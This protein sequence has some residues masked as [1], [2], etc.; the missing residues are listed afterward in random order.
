MLNESMSKNQ[1]TAHQTLFQLA[2]QHSVEIDLTKFKYEFGAEEWSIP[3]FLIAAKAA[4]LKA[5]YFKCNGA[6][7]FTKSLPAAATDHQ[8]NYFLILSLIKKP[9]PSN[10]LAL[11]TEQA[12][13]QRFSFATK[14]SENIENYEIKIQYVNQPPKTLAAKELTEIWSGDL[15]LVTSNASKLVGNKDNLNNIFTKYSTLFFEILLISFFLQALRVVLPVFFQV[16]IDKVFPNQ[17][18]QTLDVMLLGLLFSVLL[19]EGLKVIRQYLF[20]EVSHKI[21]IELD[22]KIHSH[23]L[24]VPT[25]YFSLKQNGHFSLKLK[26]LEG[27]RKFFTESLPIV[28][29]NVFLVILLFALMYYD[30]IITSVVV[31]AILLCSLI[32]WIYT[33]ASKRHLLNQEN[34]RADNHAF[35]SEMIASVR[36]IKATVSESRWQKRLLKKLASYLQLSLK[37]E[38][39]KLWLGFTRSLILW[40]AS[41]VVILIAAT[42]VI[43]GAFT[44]GAFI[45]TAILLYQIFSQFDNLNTHLGHYLKFSIAF[46][47]VKQY[48]NIEP[49]SK[50][51]QIP[52]S[53]IKG[54]VEFER[55]TFRY[56]PDSL[57]VLRNFELKILP[58]ETIGIIGETGAG[59][60]TISEL[61]LRN[62]K[63]TQG[64]I[65][66]DGHDVNSIDLFSLRRHISVISPE[67]RLFNGTVRENIC[68]S[69]THLSVHE[70]IEASM[71]AGAHEFICKLPEGYDTIIEDSGFN[72]SSSERLLIILARALVSNPSVLVFDNFFEELNP[73]ASQNIYKNIRNN[74]INRTTF[75]LSQS[76]PSFRHVDRIAVIQ[77]GE[78]VEIGSP[79]ELSLISNGIYRSLCLSQNSKHLELKNV[80]KESIRSEL[81]LLSK[82]L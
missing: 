1:P 70:M 29:D 2:Q 44:I 10:D 20:S 77:R 23:L 71:M 38:S 62:Y 63:T 61:L 58:G 53:D 56:K 16:L 35:Y 79:E 65:L 50:S 75:I 69:N 17:S 22:T 54:L 76:P 39:S 37:I 73:I 18:V 45:A 19:M 27:I 25:N 4:G 47:N 60:S 24:K 42:R 9:I 14:A 12:P 80:Q 68:T 81:T 36:T 72:L 52:L 15:I 40:I 28:C 32:S 78:I 7:L 26:E 82:F 11:G 6:E 41:L 43:D 66:I 59:K 8:G 13:R 34:H 55:T 5:R 3:E 74:F 49:E 33:L 48:F 57:D 30:P 21:S 31:I 64:R 67:S 46:N 51:D